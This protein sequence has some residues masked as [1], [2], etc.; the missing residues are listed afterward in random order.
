MN[1][2]IAAFI[3]LLAAAP[4]SA[5]ENYNSMTVQGTL[6]PVHRKIESRFLAV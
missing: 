6:S 2:T 1:K 4:A 3:F 5:S